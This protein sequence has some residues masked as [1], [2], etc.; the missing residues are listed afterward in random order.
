MRLIENQRMSD[1]ILNS[2]LKHVFVQAIEHQ[3]RK[4]PLHIIIL[5]SVYSYDG[6]LVAIPKTG[7]KVSGFKEAV[8]VQF[9]Q[10][11]KQ[12]A[13]DN[14]QWIEAQAIEIHKAYLGVGLLQAFVNV[15]MAGKYNRPDISGY[16]LSAQV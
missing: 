11:R 5:R 2:P 16:H 9:I 6:W 12:V 7:L 15:L 1:P 3:R 4:C 8:I 13:V 14:L 10:T